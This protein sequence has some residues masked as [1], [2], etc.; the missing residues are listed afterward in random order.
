MTI[1]NANKMNTY[2]SIIFSVCMASL[3]YAQVD[4]KKPKDKEKNN[5]IL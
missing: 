2:I 5:Q 4:I 1:L 3:S